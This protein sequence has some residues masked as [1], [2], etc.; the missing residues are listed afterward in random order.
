MGI[1]IELIRAG[2]G[3]KYFLKSGNPV[4]HAHAAIA[5]FSVGH[6]T[7][8]ELAEA[9]IRDCFGEDSIPNFKAAVVY[10]DHLRIFRLIPEE[11]EQI[12]DRFIAEA[13]EHGEIFIQ[14]A[15]QFLR[16]IDIDPQIYFY[17]SV[18]APFLQ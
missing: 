4:V 9:M 17:S 15:K 7:V 8:P 16:M 13:E 2:I 11:K 18:T 6:L 12:G 10:Q 3:Q 5:R 1:R 14:P